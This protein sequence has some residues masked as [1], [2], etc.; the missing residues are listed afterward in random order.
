MGWDFFIALVKLIFLL[1]LVLLL[2]YVVIRYGLPRL[3]AAGSVHGSHLRIVDRLVLN[4]KSS[5]IVIEAAGKYFLL[6]HNDGVT[7][8]IKEMDDYPPVEIQEDGVLGLAE[9]V[10]KTKRKFADRKPRQRD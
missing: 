8:L 6:A 9:M 5:I 3:G 4:S 10:Q 2:A 7:S 1:P